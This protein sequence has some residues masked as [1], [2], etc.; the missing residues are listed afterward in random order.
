[1]AGMGPSEFPARFVKNCQFGVS[2]MPLGVP[3]GPLR[4]P[5]SNALAFVHQS[6]IDELAHAA[7]QDPVAFQLKLL[8]DQKFVGEGGGAY[9]A[10]RMRGVLKAVADMSGWGKA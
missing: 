9:N 5:G 8:G 1:S 4:A 7:G 6:M 3:T 10:E 2:A